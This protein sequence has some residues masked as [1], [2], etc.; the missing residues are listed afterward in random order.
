M[1]VTS[2]LLSQLWVSAGLRQEILVLCPVTHT[3]W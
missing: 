3:G 1:I 2:P